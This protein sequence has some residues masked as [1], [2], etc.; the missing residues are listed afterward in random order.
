MVGLMSMTPVHMDAAGA[1]L[2]VV[3]VV[4][5]VHIAGMYGLSPVFGWLVDRAGAG[6]VL[7]AAALLLGASGLVCGLAAA[8]STG[9][10]SVGLVLLGLG[11]PAG[12]VGGSAM[13][14]GAVPIELRARAQGAVDVAMNLGGAVAGL[15]AGLL[16]ATTSYPVLGFVVA[17]LAVP[18]LPLLAGARP[19]PGPAAG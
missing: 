19:G 12:L 18:F 5:S 17:A 4:I 1:S 8:D 6:P 15:G 14:S 2:A 7:A 16:V 11:W 3:G 13:L 9:V 10:L